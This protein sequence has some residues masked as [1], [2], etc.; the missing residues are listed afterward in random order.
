[1]LA[2]LFS[3]ESQEYNQLTYPRFFLISQSKLKVEDSM[4][5]FKTFLESRGAVLSQTTEFLP[6][7]ALPFVPDPTKHPS[8][9][10]LFQDNWVPDL[11]VRLEKFLMLTLPA[12]P[13]PRLFEIYVSF[14]LFSV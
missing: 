10:E 12:H 4:L 3:Q 7:Y 1:M 5:S 13:Q 9:K 14:L 8:Y 11:Q 2:K 6:F